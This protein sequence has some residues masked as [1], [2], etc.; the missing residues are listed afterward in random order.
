MKKRIGKIAV[1]LLKTAGWAHLV[2]A[3][4]VFIACCVIHFVNPP[5]HSLMLYRQHALGHRIEPRRDISLSR[6]PPEL[7]EM[8]VRIEDS[9]FYRHFG[10]DPEAMTEA[11]R[12]NL[13][14]GKRFFGASTI[15]QQLARTLF[16][17][18]KKSLVRKYLEILIALEMD[19]FLTKDRILE[20]YLNSIEWGRGVFG[21]QSA[22]HHY[23]GK[24]VE[25][26]S[27][28]EM[29]RLVT[30]LPNPVK[31]NPT[32]FNRLRIMAMRYEVLKGY[33][34]TNLLK[35]GV[36][37]GLPDSAPLME[38]EPAPVISTEPFESPE[39]AASEHLSRS[40]ESN[41]APVKPDR[42]I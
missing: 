30:I 4:L 31:Y 12:N 21:I 29:M 25:E 33:E 15:N 41:A 18:P 27:G 14:M 2:L 32:N 28:D 23:F 6:I 13:R 36:T 26:L 7:V 1:F 16:L 9:K 24:G 17:Y 20:L 5:F 37:N 38:T 3:A 8:V 42:N 11:F 35:L 22:S 39:E 19:V 10:V 40:G 34:M